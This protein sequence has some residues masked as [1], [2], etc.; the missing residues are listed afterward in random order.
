MIY[1]QITPFHALNF[2]FFPVNETVLLKYNNQSDLKAC[3][4][5][6]IKLQKNDD[7]FTNVVIELCCAILV[8]NLWLLNKACPAQLF[9]FEIMDLISD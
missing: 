7:N 5:K 6:P 2:I 4:E 1:S 3:L 8:W 9:N